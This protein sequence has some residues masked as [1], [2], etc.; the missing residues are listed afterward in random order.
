V[1]IPGRLGHLYFYRGPEEMEKEE[2]ATAEISPVTKE[3]FQGKWTVPA[4]EFT[5]T[6]PELTDW[7]DGVQV[8]FVP[9]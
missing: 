9:I 2:Q 4:P 3:K 1:N 7:S 6:Q 5:A 8:P